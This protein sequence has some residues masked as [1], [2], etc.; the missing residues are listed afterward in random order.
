[1]KPDSD[2]VRA[3]RRNLLL[4]A[5]LFLVP[6]LAAVAW[7]FV[8]PRFAPAPSV[9]GTLIDPARPLEP[10]EVSLSDGE[11]YTLDDLRGHW[12]LVHRIGASCDTACRRRLHDT[13]QVRAALGED[14]IRVARVATAAN[15]RDTPGLAAVLDAHPRLSVLR[16]AADGPLAGQMPADGAGSGTVFVVDPLGNLMLRFGPGVAA[17][18]MLDDLEKLLKLSRIG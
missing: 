5:M 3:G 2:I 17:E 14:R 13:R 9:H 10:F 6:L 4:L 7:Y 8:A 18:G 11:R 15:G 12:T 1:M 16:V